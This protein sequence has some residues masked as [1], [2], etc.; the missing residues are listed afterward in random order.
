MTHL[1]IGELATAT[2]LTV[3]TLRHYDQI[4][5]LRPKTRTEGGY[6]LYGEAEVQRLQQIRSLQSLG[7]SLEQ[8]GAMIAGHDAA[9]PEVIGWQLASI[10]RELAALQRLRARLSAISQA[11]QRAGT[12]DIDDLTALMKEMTMVEKYYTEEQL[13]TLAA[14]RAA[15]GDEQIKAFEQQW[16]DLIARAERAMAEGVDPTSEPVLEI[17]REWIGLVQAFTGG[18][19]GIQQSVERVWQEEDEVHGFDAAGMRALMT[20][21][22][23]AME[24]I[25]DED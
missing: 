4:G 1:R 10:D 18:D 21:L 22:A 19:P 9:L 25:A 14:R 13:E 2:G 5:L 8:I 23:P 7:F 3:R 24:R 16:A 12:V 17:A 20:W 15:Y 6:R 11:M